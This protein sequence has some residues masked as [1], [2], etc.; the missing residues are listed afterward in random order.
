VLDMNLPPQRID[1]CTVRMDA[2]PV[3]E[4]SLRTRPCGEISAATHSANSLELEIVGIIAVL[5]MGFFELT[6][7]GAMCLSR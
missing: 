5:V 4:R 7:K 1:F 2:G 3:D 6:L